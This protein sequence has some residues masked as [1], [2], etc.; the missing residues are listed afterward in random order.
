M[1]SA[2][3]HLIAIGIDALEP[4]LVERLVEQGRLPAIAE[5]RRNGAMLRLHAP[6]E[7]GSGA[8]WPTF[9]TG[10]LPAVHG[11]HGLWTWSPE[12]MTLRELQWSHLTPFWQEAAEAGRRVLVLD[13]P[14]A[15][16][17]GHPN[18]VEIADWGA[19]DTLTGELVVRPSEYGEAV[20]CVGSHPLSSGAVDAAGHD[21]L[22]GLQRVSRLCRE[23]I[24]LRGELALE[25][26]E[27]SK[28][29]VGIIVFPEFHHAGH[30][31]WHLLETPDEALLTGVVEE[32]DGQIGRLIHRTGATPIIFGLHGMRPTRGTPWILPSI[33][34]E[35]GDQVPE[36]LGETSWRDRAA[37][38]AIG[39]KKR[40]PPGLKQ[41]YYRLVPRSVTRRLA[42]PLE[43]LRLDWSRTRA[44]SIPS[45]QHGWI[46]M[47]VR[48]RE[49]DGIVAPEHYDSARR[50]LRERLLEMRSTD[51]RPIVDDILFTTD[52][53]G[54]PSF[55]LP[56]LVVHWTDAAED[57][58]LRLEGWK[59][60]ARPRGTKFSSQHDA[61]G[62]CI[63]PPGVET[64]TA[65]LDARD[66]GPIICGS[67]RL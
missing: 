62:F 50:E 66:L 38:A 21:D 54:D 56:D 22:D 7:V 42:Q 6:T 14:F 29:D 13:V 53:P 58:P 18:L 32:L 2:T 12:T 59:S 4:K 48:G 31:L 63:L 11:I 45:D 24:R 26:W 44:F 47:N 64:S 34:E 65:D 55:L 28:P 20:R 27:K 43:P 19:H 67:S 36:P 46:R 8:V 60:T 17:V 25:L 30:L 16:V 3:S 61:L 23:G 52:A 57:S 1:P 37:M 9:V 41:I 35:M 40:I 10:H 15:P 51:G 39:I 49:R 5:A 33:L